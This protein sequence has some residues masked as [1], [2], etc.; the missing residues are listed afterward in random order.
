LV[1]GVVAVVVPVLL[2]VLGGECPREGMDYLGE[3]NA[4]ASAGLLVFFGGVITL[5]VAVVAAVCAVL[6]R[7]GWVIMTRHVR[8]L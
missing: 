2:D 1:V 3:C 6:L 8:R 4:L 5:Q 7:A